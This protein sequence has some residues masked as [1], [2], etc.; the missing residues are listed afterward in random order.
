MYISELIDFITFYIE[1]E[2]IFVKKCITLKNV[3]A[4]PI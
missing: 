2:F 1:F 3:Q 4:I